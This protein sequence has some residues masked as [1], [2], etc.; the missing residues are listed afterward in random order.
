MLVTIDI[1]N[2]VFLASISL[3]IEIEWM[4]L[5]DI[6]LSEMNQSQKDT[7][8]GS[9]EEG[10]GIVSP[11]QKLLSQAFHTGPLPGTK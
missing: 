1:M 10:A 3:K 5:E 2:Y 8:V 7:Q 11:G 9:G 6:M 4:N